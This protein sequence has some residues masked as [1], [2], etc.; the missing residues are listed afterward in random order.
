[1][2]FVGPYC[3]H[4]RVELHPVVAGGLA[5]GGEQGALAVGPGAVTEGQDLLGDVAGERVAGVAAHEAD[6][7]VVG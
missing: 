3:E 5:E 1:M 6:E 7:L 2:L 4:R